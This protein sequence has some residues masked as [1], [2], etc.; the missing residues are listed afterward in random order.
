MSGGEQIIAINICVIRKSIYPT[1]GCKAAR[2]GHLDQLPDG[3]YIGSPVTL[4]RNAFRTFPCFYGHCRK[5][6]CDVRAS[7]NVL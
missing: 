7:E 5:S 4:F 1:E 2:S 6:Y 3:V